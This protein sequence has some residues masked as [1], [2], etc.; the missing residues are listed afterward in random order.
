MERDSKSDPVLLFMPTA[1]DILDSEDQ[2]PLHDLVTACMV[3]TIC[4][5]CGHVDDKLTT[6]TN[7]PCETCGVSV[8]MRGSLFGHEER[9]L[10]TIFDC[11]QSDHSREICVLLFCALIEQ[12]LRNLVES[13]CR[14]IGVE[15]PVISLLLKG[16]R[17][18]KQRLDLFKSLT[19]S[20]FK[21]AVKDT[22]G[23]EIFSLY[24]RLKDKRN[25]LAHGATGAHYAIEPED[26]RAAVNGAASSFS[27]FADL[28]HRF[29]AIDSPPL[30]QDSI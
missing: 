4:H 23:N 6:R 27:M 22:C 12:H 11:Y 14:R 7:Q 28:F 8:P 19:G 29:C 1:S 10:L 13:R 20:K 3:F 30:P 16:Y 18:V 24:G 21:E 25:G 9:L 15:G 26:I 2:A 17:D 5:E